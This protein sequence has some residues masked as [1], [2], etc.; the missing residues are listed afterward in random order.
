MLEIDMK[1]PIFL[2][3]DQRLTSSTKGYYY[4]LVWFLKSQAAKAPSGLR[5]HGASKVMALPTEK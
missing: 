3:D 4:K 1:L 5:G 2:N